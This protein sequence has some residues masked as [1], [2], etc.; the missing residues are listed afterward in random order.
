MTRLFEVPILLS[1]GGPRAKLEIRRS[2]GSG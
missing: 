1:G 2:N